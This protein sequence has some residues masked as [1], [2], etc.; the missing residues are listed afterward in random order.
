VS[1]LAAEIEVPVYFEGLKDT[2]PSRS[3]LLTAYCFKVTHAQCE[4]REPC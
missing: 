3:L 2:G 4:T 1:S